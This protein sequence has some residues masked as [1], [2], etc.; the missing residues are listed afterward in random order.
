MQGVHKEI[1]DS[2]PDI[3]LTHPTP[4]NISDELESRLRAGL[5]CPTSVLNV[6]YAPVAEWEQIPA[7]RFKNL[8]ERLE[9]VT[10]AH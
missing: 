4:S 9:A 3:A 10:A 2:C 7:V 6:T 5:Y 8:L 1:I